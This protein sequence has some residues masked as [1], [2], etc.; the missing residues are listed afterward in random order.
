MTTL[1]RYIQIA[2]DMIAKRPGLK[3]PMRL[4]DEH[5]LAAE[6][7]VA[8]DTIRRALKLLQQQEAV[9][10]RPSR[11]TYLQPLISTAT[12]LKGKAIGFVP[13]SWANSTTHWYTST[14]FE[15]ISKW[16]DEQNCHISV[17]HTN[18]YPTNEDQWLDRVRERDLAGLIWLHPQ[19]QQVPLVVRTSKILPLVV[20]G[21][22]V[23]KQNIHSVK[24]NL[25][26]AAELIDR[27]L[28]EMGHMSYGV[29]GS[30]ILG[31]Y[32]Q[33]W[34]EAFNAAYA[35]RGSRFE[36]TFNFLDIKTLYRRKL[37]SLLMEYYEPCHPDIK[38]YV[39]THSTF[40][41]YLFADPI[42]R[43]SIGKQRSIVTV[44]YG[45][46]P[47]ASYW[48]GHEI[49][50]VVCDWPQIGRRSAEVLS[51]LVSDE[52]VPQVATSPVTFVQGETVSAYPSNETVIDTA[53]SRSDT[54]E[55]VS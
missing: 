7:K 33:N 18:P 35:K 31:G 51:S 5:T 53:L 6:H 43:E 44:D 38:A 16:A 21:R 25:M 13:P 50:H 55:P 30:D 15:G 48:T 20:A 12:N 10:R 14:V 40:M 42:F 2:N 11:G 46:Y 29:V 34:I 3:R 41:A 49:D 32:S 45:V 47:M 23:P 1:P 52:I 28:T 17:L 39:M 22:D 9:V 24:P 36:P 54:Q 27:R 26:Q 8:R 4:P 19:S 37:G